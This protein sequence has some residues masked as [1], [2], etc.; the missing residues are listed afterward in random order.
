MG[1]VVV[2]PDE[3][4]DLPG[5]SAGYQ[6]GAYAGPD[7]GKPISVGSQPRSNLISVGR[8]MVQ[9]DIAPVRPAPTV[10]VALLP[11][12]PPNAAPNHSVSHPEFA[13]ELGPDRGMAKG[14]RRV[15]H[16]APA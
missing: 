13:R 16:V 9:E 5:G 6:R 7:V 1:C 2:G 15:K 14:I 10:E 11:G 8:K 12:L 4:R 3:H